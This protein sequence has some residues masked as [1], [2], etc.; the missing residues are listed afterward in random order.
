MDPTHQP[1]PQ[2]SPPDLI[3]SMPCRYTEYSLL[4]GRANRAREKEKET[5]GEVDLY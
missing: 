3:V 2:Q 4:P 5:G 1:N